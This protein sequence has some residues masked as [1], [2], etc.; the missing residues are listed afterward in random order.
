MKLSRINSDEGPKVSVEHN[1]KHYDVGAILD[2]DPPDDSK[3]FYGW[4][5][6]NS[7]SL[8]NALSKGNIE[9]YQVSPLS[10]RIPVPALYQIR[11]FYT[12]EEHVKNARSLRNESVPKEWYEF[13]AFYYSN[14]SSVLP[15]DMPVKYPSFSKELDYELEVAAV[16]G[17]E[18]R[19]IPRG[20][21]WNYIFGFVLVCDWSAR[22]QQRKE[23]AVGLGPSKSKDFATTFGFQMTT[24]D[25]L[26]KQLT[27]EGK[28]D[29]EVWA[30]VN[31]KEYSRGNLKDMHWTFQ[32]IISWASL[33]SNLKPGD[34][35]MSGTVGN[36]CI[37]EQ[38]NRGVPYLVPKDVVEFHSRS[39][40][41][42][43]SEIVG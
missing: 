17:K 28:M 34:V 42:L 31:E 40:G 25:E 24:A 27:P 18:G 32:D 9:R 26:K 20:D 19:N 2:L 33:D 37:L 43:K 13:P 36:G 21:A 5:N 12:F 4:F 29:E 6:A 16:I 10:Y 14:I 8:K 22:D 35:I 11:D 7:A 38:S 41:S 23:R 15:S 30:T 39:L 3:S 1:G